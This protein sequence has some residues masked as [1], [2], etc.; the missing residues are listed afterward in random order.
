MSIFDR[1][2]RREAFPADA[3]PYDRP[4]D[5]IHTRDGKRL[6]V[7]HT[8][9]MARDVITK[10]AR[11]DTIERGLAL[12]LEAALLELQKRPKQ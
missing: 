5:F 6:P 8:L 12:A 4:V 3:N 7:D 10:N 11:P 1:Q 2:K 9:T